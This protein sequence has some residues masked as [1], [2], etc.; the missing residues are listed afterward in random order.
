[1]LGG[2]C[3]TDVAMDQSYPDSE[4]SWFCG[5]TVVSTAKLTAYVRCARLAP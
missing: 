4:T 1:M 5:N 2:G 3:D